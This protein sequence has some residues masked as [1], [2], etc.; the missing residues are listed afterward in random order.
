[1][2]TTRSTHFSDQF[3]ISCG[4]V[5]LDLAARKVLILLWRKNGEYLLPKGRKDIGEDIQM[6]ALRETF[7]E[8]GYKCK[9]LPHKFPTLATS[10]STGEAIEHRQATTEPFAV[11]QR[12]SGGKLKIIFW[13]LAHVDS[14]ETKTQDTQMEDEDFDTVWVDEGKVLDTLTWE[15][16]RI[17]FLAALLFSATAALAQLNLD[18][19]TIPECAR[20]CFTDAVVQA[21]CVDSDDILDPT[22]A[23]TSF[24]LPNDYGGYNNGVS[25]AS[26]T[27]RINPSCSPDELDDLSLELDNFCFD[28]VGAAKY[29]CG[30]LP[31]DPVPKETFLKAKTSTIITTTDDASKTYTV[32]SPVYPRQTTTLI[33]K[34]M[35]STS[36][37]TT[38]SAGDTST[39]T[40]SKSL[41]QAFCVSTIVWGAETRRPTLSTSRRYT[42]SSS[43]TRTRS[44][45]D[46]LTPTGPVFSQGPPESVVPFRLSG[47]PTI[48]GIPPPKPT[49]E[50]NLPISTTGV[51]AAATTTAAS[52][53][54]RARV[55]GL[56][57]GVVLCWMCFV[58]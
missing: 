46:D 49:T 4:T 38:T 18:I 8:S 51:V 14:T 50:S 34:Y 37:I 57:L 41:Y 40:T 29:H 7:E 54:E 21:G 11:S 39:Y 10:G 16:D 13:Y 2:T 15:D 23:C 43:A 33:S 25:L 44:L 53:A 35:Y 24:S 9:L 55:A 3:V 28:D 31:G 47:L 52:G 6:T 42:P 36:I 27:C 5:T 1:M 58:A 56:G 26:D 45:N 19:G 17:V 32:T 30:I 22:C 48:T 12:P 20:Q